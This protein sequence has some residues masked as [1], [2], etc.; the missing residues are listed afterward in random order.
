MSS[1]PLR[2]LVAEDEPLA[3]E[4][5]KKFLC[6]ETDF[7]IVAEAIDGPQAVAL[8]RRHRPQIVLL[9]VRLPGLN[10]FEVLAAL[11]E[12]VP[13]AVVFLTAHGEHALRAFD[14]RAVDYVMKPFT[15]ERLRK[16]LD[17]AKAQCSLR[18]EIVSKLRDRHLDAPDRIVLR[19]GARRL[20]VA[21]DDICYAISANAHCEVVTAKDTVKTSESLAEFHERLPKSRFARISRFAV[22][23]LAQVTAME[24][25]SNGD[26]NLFLRNGSVLTLT[27]TRRMSF[28]A[29]LGRQA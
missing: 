7:Q 1:P 22:V 25:K 10:G 21:L 2:I 14:A 27:R 8:T 24:P 6:S 18:S 9:D 12:E 4:R 17:R 28:F 29:L 15:R 20:L 16:A 19:A 26:Q 3:R 11:K 5:L 13:P 23:N